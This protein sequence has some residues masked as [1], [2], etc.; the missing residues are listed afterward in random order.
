MADAITVVW[1]LAKSNAGRMNG[2]GRE[3]GCMTCAPTNLPLIT[4]LPRA[5]ARLRVRMLARR[6]PRSSY[7]TAL[8]FFTLMM[9]RAVPYSTQIGSFI[10]V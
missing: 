4:R 10:S 8:W 5:R 7:A 9:W 6:A 1:F 3:P 2:R